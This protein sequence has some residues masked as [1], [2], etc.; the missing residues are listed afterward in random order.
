MSYTILNKESGS[1]L[2]LKYLKVLTLAG[3]IFVAYHLGDK[4]IERINYTYQFLRIDTLLG[5][6]DVEEASSLLDHFT[7]KPHLTPEDVAHFRTRIKEGRMKK[8]TTSLE[9]LIEQGRRTEADAL[10]GSLQ[11]EI[12][13]KSFSSY[14]HKINSITLPSLVEKAAMVT[15][16]EEISL[17]N[18][19]AKE[20]PEYDGIPEL[21]EQQLDSYLGLA[22]SYF[23]TFAYPEELAPLLQEFYGWLK[24]QDP[25]LVRRHDFSSFFNEGET[26]TNVWA[27]KRMSE[28]FR[29]GDNV[30]ITRNLGEKNNKEGNE[31][32][33]GEDISEVPLGTKGIILEA[34]SGGYKVNISGS[35][36]LFVHGELRLDLSQETFRD[37]RTYFTSIKQYVDQVKSLEVGQ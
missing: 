30:V 4:L 17:I 33:Y 18:L 8:K 23:Q 13:S 29:A 22:Q 21:R 12:P 3:G 9:K 26:Y 7:S 6:G 15:G 11:G 1:R 16:R 25:D 5:N 2:G 37:F 32:F 28:N 27:L 10:L 36:S 35:N 20:Y 31:Y 24:K 19:I 14:I 34:F